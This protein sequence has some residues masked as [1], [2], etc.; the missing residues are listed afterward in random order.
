MKKL[1]LSAVAEEFELISNETR[2]F[3]NTITGE[4]EPYNEYMEIDDE[5]WEKYE[6]YEWISAPNQYDLG[7][8][9]VMADFADTVSDPHKREMLVVALEGKGAFRRFRDTVGRV[10]LKDEWYAFKHEAYIKVAR[11][12]CEE[13][14]IPYEY[15]KDAKN[16]NQSPE[17]HNKLSTDVIVVQ[18]TDKMTDDVVTIL[19]ETLNYKEHDAK[20]EVR[21]ISSKKRIALVA[22]AKNPKD[23]TLRVAGIIGAVP[24][25]GV[26]GWELHPLAV[27]PAYQKQG[28]GTL[29]MET[30]E[31]EVRACGG[32]MMYLGSDDETGTTSLFGEDLYSDTFEKLA[33]IKN[34]GGHPYSF[35]EKCGYKIVGVFPDANGIGKPDIWMAKR[36][37]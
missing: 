15:P 13:N 5:D 17:A 20:E 30:L 22:I 12:W 16:Q 6:G 11:E 27:L 29:L 18:L 8:H 19:Q 25:Y 14:Q 36:L 26:T 1:N 3:Y 34:T 35:Y 28:I 21:R 7:E 9:E 24:Q 23:G 32:V 31:K 10:G 37:S 2:L 4:F 33:N